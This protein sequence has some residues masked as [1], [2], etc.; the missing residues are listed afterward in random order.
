MDDVPPYS[1]DIELL[2]PAFGHEGFAGVDVP[3]TGRSGTV[4]Y[5]T[6]LQYEQA[7]LTLYEAVEDVELGAV[8]SNRFSAMAGASVDLER[9]T[10][11]V[12]VPTALNWGGDLDAYTADGFGLGDV[13]A[14]AR[15][16]VV[17]TRAVGLGVRTGLALP[18][19]KPDAYMGEGRT[20]FAVGALG[21]VTLGQL[22]LATD[23][24]LATRPTVR[25]NEDWVASNELGWGNAVRWKL[26]DATRTG[27]DAQVVARSGLQSFLQGGAENAIEALGGVEVYPSRRATLGFHVGRGL[28]EG[29]GTTDLRLLTS[30][31]VEAAP[32]E[33]LPPPPLP[34]VKPLRPPVVE[35]DWPPPEPEPVPQGGVERRGDEIVI[36]DRIE[37][38][39]DTN[40]LM[41]YSEPVLER[42]AAFINGDARIASVVI[43]GHASQEGNY[44]HNY[45]LAESRA[46]RVWEFLLEQGVAEARIAYR[47]LGKVHPLV[48]GEDE[49]SLQQNRRVRFLVTRQYGPDDELPAYPETQVLPWSGEVVPVVQPAVPEPP[50]EPEPEEEFP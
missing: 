26:P 49:E 36:G 46:R 35:D 48:E 14:T 40:I 10:F 50:P 8:V 2:R 32:R 13:G 47:G 20:R 24:G 16:V 12:L 17:E 34:P 11:G 5:G 19:G 7:P 3:S 28:T 18:T 30:L 41:D 42:V 21:A 31:V 23:L 45:T 4:R 43:E 38:V 9:V 22:T 15:L 44:G 37:F 29:T 27:L 39:V 6:V 33:P 25:T 1:I